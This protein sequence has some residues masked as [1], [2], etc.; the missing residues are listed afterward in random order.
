[1]KNGEVEIETNTDPIRTRFFISCGGLHSDRIARLAQAS[2][3]TRIIPFRGEY[4]EL[5]S[6]KRY[7]VRNLIYPVPNPDFPFLGVH[8]TRMIG[9]AVHAE[10]NAVLSFKREGYKR[11]DFALRDALESIG[12]PG[13]WRLSARHWSKGLR[14]LWRSLSKKAFTRSLQRLIPEVQEQDLIPA[15]AGVRAQALVTDGRLVEDFLI[16]RAENSIHVCNAPSPA[17]TSSL[18]IGQHIA[19]QALS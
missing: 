1:M 13:F 16:V 7:L 3:G 5:K 9:G 4:Y 19:R 17:A 10:P 8:F 12:Y 14:E 2:L 18:L 15:E 11:S 6:D